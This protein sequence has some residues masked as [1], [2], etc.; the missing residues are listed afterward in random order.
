VTSNTVI[1]SK[2]RVKNTLSLDY[3]I[4]KA[5]LWIIIISLLTF[6]LY[7]II[8]VIST[9]F[10]NK[11]VFTLSNYG[12]LFNARNIKLIKNSVFVVSLSSLLGTIISLSIALFA[13]VGKMKKKKGIYKS[14]LFTMVSPPFVSSLALITLFGR[15]GFITSNLLGLSVNPYGWPGIVLLQALGKVPLGVIMLITA[16]N[17]IDQRQILAS[18]DLGATSFKTLK[19]IL[20]P[21]ILPTI[22]SVLFLSFTMNLADFGTPIIIGGKFKMLA[23]EIYMTIFSSSNLGKAAAMNVLLI[24]PAVLAFLFY[25]KSMDNISN[26]SEGLKTLGNQ[27]YGFDVPL[28]L[29]FFLGIVTV[30]FFIISILKY[31]TIFLTAI[32]INPSGK[33]M[34]TLEHIKKVKMAYVPVIIRSI[35]FAIIAGVVSSVVG[36]LLS[37][38]THR[39]KIAGMKYVEFVSALPYIIPGIFFGLGYIVAFKSRPLLLTGTTAIVVLNI[40]FRHISVANKAANAAFTTID[41]R[42]EDASRDLG[43]S[44]FKSII[45]IVFPILKPIF[46]TSFINTF[47]ANMTTVGAIIF[48]VSP[49]NVVAS[50]VMFKE[51]I[52]GG[53]GQASVMAGILILITVGINLVAVKLLD[54][55]EI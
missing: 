3:I 41:T 11:G 10:Y 4:D 19:N 33:I 36:I 14:M 34:F 25:K 18:R 30:S 9:S 51:I 21:G 55:E 38:Y 48:L 2:E 52:N 17:A 1:K 15:R 35:N 28:P 32:S 43:A 50:I 7:P 23:T 53:Y 40:T 44:H 12:E 37:Y 31:G 6:I 24:P 49:R 42:L 20:L 8:K 27:S 16:I 45:N 26:K 29:K 46:L 47:S 13:F 22:L 5:I 54:K 39:R